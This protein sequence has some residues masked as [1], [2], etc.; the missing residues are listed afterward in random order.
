[1]NIEKANPNANAGTLQVAPSLSE[2]RAPSG[3]TSS[4]TI[5]EQPDKRVEPS[6]KV[7]SQQLRDAVQT[8]SSFVE[9]VSDRSL[10]ISVDEDLS[11][12]VVKVLNDQTEEVVRQIPSEEVLN[13]M[14]Q[15]RAISEDNFG[16]VRGLLL[17]KDV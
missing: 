1:M 3:E 2:V 4:A 5:V 14:K 16:D 8:L 7:D 9:L 15:L 6:E 11:K 10:S 13:M 12:I 17:S